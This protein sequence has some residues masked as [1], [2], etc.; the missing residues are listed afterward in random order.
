MLKLRQVYNYDAGLDE[1][2]RTFGDQIQTAES[3]CLQY[4]QDESFHPPMPPHAV[5]QPENSEQVQQI[6]QNLSQA[7]DADYS[8]WR[9]HFPGG[10]HSGAQRWDMYR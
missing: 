3:V 7:Q 1:L 5:V 6:V 9:R 10:E 4:G 8:P 2:I